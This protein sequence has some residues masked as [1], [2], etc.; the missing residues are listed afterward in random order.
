MPDSTR[1]LTPD[2]TRDLPWWGL[3]Q[4][5]DRQHAGHHGDDNNGMGFEQRQ[6]LLCQAPL[7]DLNNTVPGP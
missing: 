5:R 2:P 1:D 4:G 6:S 7:D 3:R